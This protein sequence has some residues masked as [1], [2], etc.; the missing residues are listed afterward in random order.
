MSPYHSIAQD[1]IMSGM[2]RHCS[3]LYIT[4]PGIS[5][6]KHCHGLMHLVSSNV[7]VRWLNPYIQLLVFVG[8]VGEMAL[9]NV[10]ALLISVHRY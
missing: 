2:S 8:R 5:S 1:I 4:W 9:N 6:N 7:P 3:N 10:P